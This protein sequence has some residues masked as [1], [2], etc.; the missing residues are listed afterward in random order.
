M[1]FIKFNLKALKSFFAIAIAM[2]KGANVGECGVGQTTTA[3]PRKGMPKFLSRILNHPAVLPHTLALCLVLVLGVGNVW[4][5]YIVDFEGS[6]ETKTA[7]A[8]GNVTLNSI[9]WNMT[10]A[11]IGTGSDDYKNGLR[12]A[13]FRGYSSSS[14]TMNANKSNG[15][16]SISFKYWRYGTDPQATWKVEY[17]INNGSSWIQAGSNF[18]PPAN[19]NEQTFSATSINVTEDVRIRIVHVSGGNIGTQR[20]FNIDDITLTNYVAP[21]APTITSITPG[22]AQLSVA[23]TA[24]SDGGSA[25]TNY[26]YSTDGGTSWRNRASGTTA[27]PLVISTLST[28]GTTALTNGVSYN[29]QIRAVNAVGGGTAT[30]STAATPRTTPSAPTITGITPGNQQLSVAFTAP[31][32]DGGA[33]ITDYK[34]ST[35]G[36]GSFTSASSTTS[37]IVITG[38][39]NGTSYNVQIRAVNAAGDGTATASTA[40]IPLVTFYSKSSGDI[41]SFSSWGDNTN[42]TG[43]EPTDFTSAGSVYEIRNRSSATIGANWT[44]SGSNS[45]VVVGDG[46]NAVDFSIPAGMSVSISGD[47]TNRSTISGDGK[48]IM[49]GSS[50]QTISGA[51]TISNLEINNSAGVTISSGS[52]MQSLTGVL[53]PTAGTLTTNGNLTLKSTATG[54]ARVA[55]GSSSGGYVSGNVSVERHFASNKQAWRLVTAPV[56]GSSSNFIYEHWQSSTTGGATGVEIW[57]PTG[58]AAP[59]GSG[60]ANGLAYHA[61]VSSMREWNNDPS[62]PAYANVTDTKSTPLFTADAANPKSYFLFVA[63][64]LGNGSVPASYSAVKVRATGALRQ[65]NQSFSITNAQSGRYFMVGNPYAS[66]VSHGEVNMVNVD[67]PVW[68]WDPNLSGANGVGGYVSFDR[69]AKTYSVL[70]GQSGTGLVYT[71]TNTSDYTRLQSGQAFFVRAT[72]T[73]NLSVNFTEADKSSSST[74]TVL[75]SGSNFQAEKMRLTLQRNFNGEHITTDGAVAFFYAGGATEVNDMDGQKLMNASNNIM[76]RRNGTNLTFEHRPPVESNDTLFLNLRSTSTGAYRLILTG[77]DFDNSNK[78]IPVLQDTYLNKEQILKLDTSVN[79]DFEIDGN[80]TASSGE[81]F[82]IVFSYKA[83]EP[84]EFGPRHTIQGYPNPLRV[85]EQ[86]NLKFND[87]PAGNYTVVFNSLQ[88]ARVQ[89]QFVQHAGGTSVQNIKLNSKLSPGSYLVNVLDASSRNVESL[90]IIIQ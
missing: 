3:I 5:Q 11:L 78:L 29:I 61:T 50:A 32:S 48:V 19:N 46:T 69:T 67:N 81:R 36:G 72:N 49:S 7:Y 65:G 74:N 75:R 2:R 16:G 85:G 77:S 66:P 80:A 12:S 20:R 62:S 24:G 41:N 39:T 42:G 13:R 86:L 83:T 1:H 23:F 52:N 53:T 35:D 9:Q 79:Y 55:T 17:S 40:A 82:R 33:A 15:L 63:G 84:L 57:G 30:A 27:S 68:L 4:G 87:R 90:K 28:D 25:I 58:S 64:P 38:L 21:A 89:Q 31:S 45:K 18:S 59:T 44:V 14:F 43:A 34:Y 70:S 37:P 8:S 26:Q 22:D 51:G 88:G 56:A 71:G 6:G 10:D 60:G 73:A 76:F 47:L 54:T